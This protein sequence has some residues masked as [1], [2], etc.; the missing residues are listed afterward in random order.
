M[1]GYEGVADV[2]LIRGCRRREPRADSQNPS[3][4]I[5]ISSEPAGHLI[6]RQIP[7]GYLRE[8]VIRDLPEFWAGCGCKASSCFVLTFDG[9]RD[10][11][12]TLGSIRL[13]QH[14]VNFGQLEAGGFNFRRLIQKVQ[15]H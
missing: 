8:G 7:A 15:Q 9:L 11:L 5:V 10:T 12:T 1:D 4:D 13:P 6:K 14:Q 3:G 2:K